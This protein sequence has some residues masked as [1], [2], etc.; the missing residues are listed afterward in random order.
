MD[1]FKR[2]AV[3]DFPLK[4][5]LV[6]QPVSKISSYCNPNLIQRLFNR[7]LILVGKKPKY[8][9]S[10]SRLRELRNKDVIIV[11]DTLKNYS[12]VC[13]HIEEV[14]TESTKLVL[15]LWNPT[16]HSKDYEKISDKWKI[17]SFSKEDSDKYG[18]QFVDTFYNSNLISQ[19]LNNSTSIDLFFIGTD[20]GR[21]KTLM[22]IQEILEKQQI[23]YDFRIVDNLKRK[24]DSRYTRGL[25]YTEV[26]KLIDKA[27]VLLEVT[28]SNQNA[29]TLRTMEA[30][31]FRKKLVT[32][33][34]NVRNYSF[35]R[36]DNIFILGEDSL[37]KLKDFIDSNYV[38]LPKEIVMY[39]TF[40]Q[41]LER[42][43][44]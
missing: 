42:I 24:Y 41:W 23:S 44:K 19:S 8:K 30:L 11:F 7:L 34:R 22:T 1:Q 10:T 2:I 15:Y 16:S 6:N 26:C 43:S 3:V 28:Q 35:Y 27:K 33:N 17:A 12:D 31:F 38:E 40:D 36:K 20:K 25:K 14:V 18:F 4:Y 29:P 9:V 39:Y 13:Q 32:N 5:F 37:D 21:L